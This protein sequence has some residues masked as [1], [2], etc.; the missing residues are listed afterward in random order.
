ML[1]LD[2]FIGSLINW[3]ICSVKFM[4]IFVFFFLLIFWI[5]LQ[6]MIHSVHHINFNAQAFTVQ[7]SDT[8]IHH[9]YRNDIEQC[10]NILHVIFL[11]FGMFLFS[12]SVLLF[13]CSTRTYSIHLRPWPSIRLCSLFVLLYLR[14]CFISQNA[15]LVL[16]GIW[17]DKYKQKTGE[18]EH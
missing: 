1:F 4:S 9:T 7:I 5:I 17:Y 18:R 3:F 16:F 11:V 6:Q 15:L 10:Q 12:S 2:C 13:L 14:A 8:T